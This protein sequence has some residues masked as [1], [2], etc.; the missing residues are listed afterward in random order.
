MKQKVFAAG[1]LFLL[2]FLL[3]YPKEALEASREGMQLWLN[4]LFPTLLPPLILTGILVHTNGIEKLLSPLRVL[5]RA[6]LGLSPSGAYV[7]LLGIL[8]GYPMGAKLASDLFRHGKIAK[9]EAEYLL[10]FCSSP[11]PAFIL[12]YLSGICLEGKISS[13]YILGI[14]L[15]SNLVC[16]FFFRFFV[17]KNQTYTAYSRST[18][19]ETISSGSLGARIDVSIMNGFETIARLGGY[20]LL[21][22]ILSACLNHYFYLATERNLPWGFT[23]FLELTTGLMDL[24]RSTLTY[25]RRFILSMALTSFGGLCVLAQTRSVLDK[26]LS[27]MPYLCAKFLSAAVTALTASIFV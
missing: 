19:K 13:A 24:T 1:I 5:W 17:Y 23:G 16:M 12:S 21:F 4:T 2:S 11:S 26:Q 15:F 10:T 20:I 3:C 22:S 6:G 14:L 7:F 25:S 27:L 8:C 18:K 9:K